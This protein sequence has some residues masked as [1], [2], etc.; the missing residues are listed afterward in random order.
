[1]CKSVFLRQLW[2]VLEAPD[3]EL[4]WTSEMA[5]GGVVQLTDVELPEIYL[6]EM[7][8]RAG[9]YSRGR[10]GRRSAQPPPGREGEPGPARAHQR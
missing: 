1:M 7:P 10:A 4:Y 9:H 6:H 8:G 2:R 3:L 5:A